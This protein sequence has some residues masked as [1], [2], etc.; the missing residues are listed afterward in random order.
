MVIIIKA[1]RRIL[2]V[3]ELF[4]TF[5]VVVREMNQPMQVI[6]LHRTRYAHTQNKCV[7]VKLGKSE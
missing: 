2:A 1:S 4:G 3:F 7:Q 6:Q 5:K